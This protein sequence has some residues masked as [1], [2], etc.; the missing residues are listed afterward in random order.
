VVLPLEHGTALKN[1]VKFFSP[2]RWC[3]VSGMDV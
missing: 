2:L 3:R 1:A